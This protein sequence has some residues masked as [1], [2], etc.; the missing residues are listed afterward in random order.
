MVY[1]SH[2]SSISSYHARCIIKQK[3]PADHSAADEQAAAEDNAGSQRK[4]HFL[5]KRIY[6][7]VR[8]SGPD[9]E[10]LKTKRAGFYTETGTSDI[11]VHSTIHGIPFPC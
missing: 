7:G 8:L 5:S 2:I 4:A 9:V 11:H 3:G 1:P 6:F 10:I